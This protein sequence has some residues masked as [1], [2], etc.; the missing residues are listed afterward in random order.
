MKNAIIDLILGAEALKAS[1]RALRREAQDIHRRAEAK[2]EE[3][4]EA[5]LMGFPDRASDLLGEH[6]DMLANADSRIDSASDLSAELRRT[7]D[8][9]FNYEG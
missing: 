6:Y 8:D 2:W 4:H 1:I 3:A 7:L 5:A 9:I